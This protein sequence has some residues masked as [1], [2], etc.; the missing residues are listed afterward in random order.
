[1]RRFALLLASLMVALG[2]LAGNTL[3]TS[4]T[5]GHPGDVVQVTMSLDNTDAIVALEVQLPLDDNLEYVDASATLEGA[6]SNGH[7]L[8][9]QFK[10]G[11]LSMYIFNFTN[12]PLN[13]GSGNLLSFNLRLANEPA[14]YALAPTI[15][16]SDASSAS[17]NVQVVNGSVTILSPKITV[18]TETVDYGHVP[19]RSEYSQTVTI[20][21]SGN[22]TLN[23]TD[24]QFSVAELT[25]NETAFSVEPGNTKSL[26]VK[27][28]PVN[29][30]SITESIS[31][32]SNAVNGTAVA[33]VLADPFSV[34]ELHVSSVSGASDTEVELSLTMNNMEPIVAV[35][36]QF[37][38][39]DELHFV[40]GSLV[41]STRAEN[42]MKMASVNG[43]VLTLYIYSVNNTAIS[44]NDGEIATFRLMLDGRSGYYIVSPQSV[45]LS[46]SSMENMTSA[47]TNGSVTIQSPA[48]SYASSYSMGSQDIT[49]TVSSSYPVTNNGQIDLVINKVNFLAEGF[50]IDENLPLTIHA[51]S[52]ENITVVYAAANSGAFGGTMN[53]YSNDPA[54]R[55]VSVSLSGTVYEP[56]SIALTG[57]FTNDFQDY[58]LHISLDNYTGIVGA[59]MDV[60]V[61]EGFDC[62]AVDL[63][64]TGRIQ[65][66][67][68]S[69]TKMSERNYR[70]VL[71]SL[72][73][74]A[75]QGNTGK[76]F[77]LTLHASDVIDDGQYVSFSNIVLSDIGGKNYASESTASCLVE[78]PDEMEI[79]EAE[80]ITLLT[81]IWNGK[82]VDVTFKRT[83]SKDVS[84]TICLPFSLSSNQAAAAG[85]F[86]EFVGVDMTTRP[87]WTVIMQESASG[88]LVANRPYLFVPA[89]SGQVIF[90]GTVPNDATVVAG[91]SSAGEWSFKGTYE[92]I[93]WQSDPETI[94]GFASG[95]AYGEAQATEAGTFIRV[96]TGGIRPFRA[97]LDYQPAQHAPARSGS[98]GQTEPLPER[99]VVRLLSS[100]GNTTAVGTINT[101]TGEF[102]V[103]A[104]YTIDG[105]MLDSK[106]TVPGVYIN[107]TKKVIIK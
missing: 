6:R 54:N 16:A 3:T 45:L 28:N 69:I 35:Q 92:T 1:M 91:T 26:T 94:Y 22:E 64:G 97:Y 71:F 20:R 32:V 103:D 39:P 5:S 86:Y 68:S 60:N 4:S 95:Q 36:C 15:V 89:A 43:N 96:H 73:N 61:P 104:W 59:Q 84:S 51:G 44:G 78:Y 99:M 93:E 21:N 88:S 76:I 75:V 77:T 49:Q 85:T 18:V 62:S 37:T 14:T 100:D 11:V 23:V 53:I 9:T 38:L 67:S 106:P 19:I 105:I 90:S 56:N 46:N 87:Y 79:T 83:F 24:V 50:S 81:S 29:R 74:A 42:L 7:S 80:G 33:N 27:Y 65:G 72:S 34:N 2:C 10:N 31:F 102:K 8:S 55:M 48:I 12:E 66:M 17:L 58:V 47:T 52:T 82:E 98:I 41:L 30:G 70:I 63:V 13:G 101:Q 25:T 57:E 107:K 40:D